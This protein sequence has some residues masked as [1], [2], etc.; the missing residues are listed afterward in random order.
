MQIVKHLQ[1]VFEEDQMQTRRGVEL[2]HSS[3]PPDNN[4]TYNQIMMELITIK[5]TS[6]ALYH[7][8]TCWI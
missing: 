3:L 8:T 4:G 6:Q 1:I 5:Y 2:R 7:C